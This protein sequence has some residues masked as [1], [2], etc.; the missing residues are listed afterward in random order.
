MLVFS[1]LEGG[2]ADF[3]TGRDLTEKIR[4]VVGGG[5]VKCAVAYWGS[6]GFDLDDVKNWK[7]VCDIVGGSTSPNALTALGAP[8][9]S[10]LKHHSNLHSKVYL[11][12]RGAVIGSANASAGGLHTMDRSSRML[13]A[14]V[15]YDAD[16]NIWH[17]A[18]AW[19]DQLFQRADI[20]DVKALELAQARYSPPFDEIPENY[21]GMTI[22][23]QIV[24]NPA[25]FVSAG[26]G[27]VI[28]RNVAS[29]DEISQAANESASAGDITKAVLKKWDAKRSFI[30][31]SE[32]EMAKLSTQFI[33]FYIGPRGGKIVLTHQ[34]A[35]RFDR[36]SDG[37][38]GHFYT[39][40]PKQKIKLPSGEEFPTRKDALSESDWKLILATQKT[41]SEGGIWG[42]MEFS[43]MLR[44]ATGQ[45][46]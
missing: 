2:M 37:D 39:N 46:F 31:W 45:I 27:F 33:E 3:V 29:A 13:E 19:F 40:D 11:S 10:S 24:S 43:Q 15:Y 38:R 18:T 41:N 21:E 28:T 23:Q 44:S 14:G 20:V 9:N 6:H 25:Y 36:V 4:Y 35:H 7:I 1:K 12:D 32:K 22:L 26:V 8:T 5:E 30:E 42:A 16:D 17:Q 34:L